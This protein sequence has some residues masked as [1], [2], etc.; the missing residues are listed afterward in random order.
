MIKK[1][2]KIVY[3]RESSVPLAASAMILG[4]DYR[5][6]MLRSWFSTF[7]P[8]EPSYLRLQVLTPEY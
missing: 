8:F 1:I 3:E 7:P 2:N 5:Q 6:R 4:Q